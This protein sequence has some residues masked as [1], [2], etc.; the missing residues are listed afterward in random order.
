MKLYRALVKFDKDNKIEVKS[1]SFID[2]Q[3]YT[4]NIINQT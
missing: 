1:S 2:P 3:N 4:L